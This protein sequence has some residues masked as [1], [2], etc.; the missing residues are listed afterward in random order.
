MVSKLKDFIKDILHFSKR[1]RNGIIIL[2]ILIFIVILIQLLDIFKV[3]NSP[4]NFSEIENKI[5]QFRDSI[6][7]ERKND[8][9]KR[10]NS[11][12]KT[13]NA[14]QKNDFKNKSGK[15]PFEKTIY[16]N[17]YS[18]DNIILGLNSADSVDLRKIRGIG[19]V[20]SKRIVKYRNILGGFYSIDQLKEV[21]GIDSLLY[22][23]IKTNF[24]IDTNLIEK[25]N[26]NMINEEEL[27]KHPYISRYEAKGII[28]Y[29]E[30][31]NGRINNL[32]D[33]LQNNILTMDA[34]N[35]VYKYLSI[36]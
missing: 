4:S 15:K 3:N 13:K 7:I 18:N 5:N 16:I 32:K 23:E 35:R 11:K 24:N 29:R 36:N 19:K 10:L 6:L 28:T 34:Y 31:K 21:Y 30:Y 8:S 22:E 33:L 9:I 20:L 2:L 12:N 14:Y 25:I 27:S 1:D 26:I 17:N